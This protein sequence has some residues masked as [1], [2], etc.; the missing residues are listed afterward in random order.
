MP[1]PPY[2]TEVHDAANYTVKSLELKNNSWL[3]YELQ[4]ILLA[5][6]KVSFLGS[7]FAFA[8]SFRYV[9]LWRVSLCGCLITIPTSSFLLREIAIVDYR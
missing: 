8:L 1:L 9:L 7:I 4:D 3:S 2:D 5:K 6:A